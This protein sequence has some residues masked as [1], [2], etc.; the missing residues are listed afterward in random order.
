MTND[1]FTKDDHMTVPRSLLMLN[2]EQLHLLRQIKQT[3]FIVPYREGNPACDGKLELGA[4]VIP[5][6]ALADSGQVYKKTHQNL[7][8][9]LTWADLYQSS[10][11]ASK[12]MIMSQLIKAVRVHR[13][14]EL[15]IDF[16]IA[17]EQY[18]IGF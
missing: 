8:E 3:V 12:R 15:D 11:M 14:Y 5:N 16:N 7:K 17:Y 13:D 10:S 1:Y 4:M 2:Y 6:G 9:L 18:C